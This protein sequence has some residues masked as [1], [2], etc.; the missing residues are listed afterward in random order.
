MHKHRAFGKEQ[1]CDWVMG[2]R[3]VARNESGEVDGW[4]PDFTG[5]GNASYFIS[6]CCRPPGRQGMSQSG[7]GFGRTLKSVQRMAQRGEAVQTDPVSERAALH[8]LERVGAGAQ[9]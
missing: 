7:P 9:T 6:S 2:W 8:G 1:M 4:R 3:R 5:P